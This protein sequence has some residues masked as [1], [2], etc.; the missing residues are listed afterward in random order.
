MRFGVTVDPTE[1]RFAIELN[2]S[3][4]QQLRVRAPASAD[5][6]VTFK[7]R[8]SDP[9]RYSTRPAVGIVY[10]GFDALVTVRL[11]PF[12]VAPGPCTDKLQIRKPR[13]GPNAAA[14][15]GRI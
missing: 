10:P 3:A 14:P 2:R 6:G 12:V 4:R 5:G 1:L 9:K 13:H 11:V 7:V 15:R 8:A